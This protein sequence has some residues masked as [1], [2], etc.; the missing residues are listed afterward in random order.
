MSGNQPLLHSN[1]TPLLAL[2]MPLVTTSVL[3]MVFS[4][5]WASGVN[6]YLVVLILGLA[7]KFGHFAQIP[8]QLART[9]V[10]I[11]AGVLY[12]LEF[13]ADKVPYLDSTW[14]AISTVLRP[15]V[16]AVIAALIAQDQT[17]GEQLAYAAL[18]GATAF[19][20]HSVKSGSRLAINASP[21]PFTNIGASV[22]EDL[23]V[24]GVMAL[25]LNHP[26]IALGV[27]GTLL[28]VGLFL[29]F[30]I[31]RRIRHGWRKWKRIEPRAA[32]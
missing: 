26:W 2:R 30:V 12:A 7:D 28:I 20:S 13:V 14:D 18:G 21:E 22:G 25:A 10:L 29:L 17:S 8:D 23:T 3:P 6:A 11:G 27:S 9:D 19:A 32:Q 31:L 24:A 15:T 16:A 4:S 5:S 1:V